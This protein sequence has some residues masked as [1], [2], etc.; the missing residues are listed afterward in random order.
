MISSIS[1]LAGWVKTHARIGQLPDFF[2]LRSSRSQSPAPLTL[3]TALWLDERV[4]SRL[5]SATAASRSEAPGDGRGRFALWMNA[6]SVLYE[7]G[8]R[9][10]RD[11]LLASTVASEESGS[12][13]GTFGTDPEYISR[14]TEPNPLGKTERCFCIAYGKR[15]NRTL[16]N[17][18]TEPGLC[19]EVDLVVM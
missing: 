10:P 7:S 19:V 3:H 13:T 11:G 2:F 17:R 16:I 6:L 8:V 5:C 9:I 14:L 18:L 1:K 12:F 15:L 4:L